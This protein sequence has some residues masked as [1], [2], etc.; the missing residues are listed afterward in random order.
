MEIPHPRLAE[1]RFVLI[2]LVEL[3]P[4]IHHPVL[5]KTS[6]EILAATQDRSAVRIWNP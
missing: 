2:P 3:A 4:E 1:R 6:S 5:G